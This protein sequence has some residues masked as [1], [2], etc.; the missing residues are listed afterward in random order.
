MF[1][2]K[3][4]ADVGM[5]WQRSAIGDGKPCLTAGK[6]QSG[7]ACGKKATINM[8]LEVAQ[9]R[10]TSSTPIYCVGFLLRR[11]RYATPA[12]KHSEAPSALFSQYMLISLI[13][14]DINRGAVADSAN[15]PIKMICSTSS[16]C[17][18]ASGCAT[19]P[20]LVMCWLRRSSPHSRL[21]R[22]CG[23]MQDVTARAVNIAENQEIGIFCEKS[24][25]GASLC[26]TA[27]VA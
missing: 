6:P 9:H 24:A 5:P 15:F 21:R 18:V 7:V 23:V 27:G 17:V 26:L 25:E 20:R 1:T 14:S 13:I 8:C 12:V 11:F 16:S 3:T 19:A 22:Q 10:S 2:E 4:L